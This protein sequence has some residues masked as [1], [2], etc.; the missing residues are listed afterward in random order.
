MGHLPSSSSLS[1]DTIKDMV[2]ETSLPCHICGS[3][4]IWKR[5]HI[6][7]GPASSSSLDDSR[8]PGYH[9]HQE[10]LLLRKQDHQE[11]LD[12]TVIVVIIGGSKG[13]EHQ[14]GTD[15]SLMTDAGA[16]NL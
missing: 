15:H 4:A 12:V 9:H 1:E 6:S 7:K 13:E 11:R 14:E 2:S 8:T 16:L 5:G 10:S 3:S